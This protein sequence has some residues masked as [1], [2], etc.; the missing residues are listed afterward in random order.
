MNAP[1]PLILA[2]ASRYRAE[3]LGR[4]GVPFEAIAADVDETPIPGEPPRVLAERLAAAKARTLAAR[5]P[6]RWVL[7]SDQVCSCGGRPLGK[8]GDPETARMQLRAQSGQRVEFFT[9]MV[10]MRGADAAHHAHTDVTIVRF[11]TLSDAEIARYLA[12]EAVLDCAGAF[13]CEGLGISL[14][15]AIESTDPTALVGLPL[16][17][18]A[19]LLR[20][21][22]CAVP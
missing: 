12:Q 21:T 8:P 5:H 15:D 6:Q 11:R 10:L 9:A 20:Q 7:G 14:F 17:A 1:P 3:L 16:I 22:G 4:L 2:S 13:K 18:L 19:R